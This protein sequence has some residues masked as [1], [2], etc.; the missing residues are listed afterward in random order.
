MMK[1]SENKQFDRNS[2]SLSVRNVSRFDGYDSVLR[3]GA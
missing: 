1:S 3:F 2:Y